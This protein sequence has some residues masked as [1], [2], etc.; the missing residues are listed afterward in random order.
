MLFSIVCADRPGQL[1]LRMANRAA[2]LAYLNTQLAVIVEAGPLL[3]IEGKLCGSQLIIDV[4]DRVAAEAFA[5]N[6]PYAKAG[7]FESVCVR[8]YRRVFRNGE[9]LG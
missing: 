6:D 2:H 7:L 3:D 8:P 1:E 9:M 4:A 5:A